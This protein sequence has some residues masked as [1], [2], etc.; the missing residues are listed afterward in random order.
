MI[1][2]VKKTILKTLES[3]MDPEINVSIVDLGLVYDLKVTK[4]NTVN[5]TMT[6]TSMGC[7]LFGVIEEDIRK[8][9]M[10]LGF[11]KKDIKINLTF[12][13]AWSMKRITK[14]GKAMMGI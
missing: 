13:P 14:K 12:E 6:L 9:I 5:L 4:D 8:K 2:K 1:Q 3:V 10:K 7:P 11:K